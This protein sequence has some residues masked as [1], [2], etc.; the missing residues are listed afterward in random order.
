MRYNRADREL[1]IFIHLFISGNKTGTFHFCNVMHFFI[2]L[3][4]IRRDLMNTLRPEL[5]TYVENIIFHQ[6]NVPSHTARETPFEID[7]IG[8]QS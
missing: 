2:A 7:L 3:L 5:K 1:C 6:N 4:V 8:L